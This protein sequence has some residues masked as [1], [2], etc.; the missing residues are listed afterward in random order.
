MWRNSRSNLGS[1]SWHYSGIIY[2]LL[3][4]GCQEKSCH[5]T[6]SVTHVSATVSARKHYLYWPF[7]MHLHVIQDWDRRCHKSWTDKVS[8]HMHPFILLLVWF[9]TNHVTS[10]QEDTFSEHVILYIDL[11]TLFFVDVTLKINGYLINQV[12]YNN[13]T[14]NLITK[15][16]TT[17]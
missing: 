7:S 2:C 5:S 3:L 6:V 14:V 17:F 4:R 9:T 1:G 15:P 16:Y 11:N 10:R 13:S 12:W 8:D